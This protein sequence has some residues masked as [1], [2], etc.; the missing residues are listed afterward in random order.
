[1]HDLEPVTGT[2]IVDRSLGCAHG[3]AQGKAADTAHTVDTN[4]HRDLSQFMQRAETFVISTIIE[5]WNRSVTR[6]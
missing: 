2:R 1:M 3:S 4:F 5:S 6:R